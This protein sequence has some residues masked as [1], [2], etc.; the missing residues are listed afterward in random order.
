MNTGKIFSI[1]KSDSKIS[2]L[3]CGVFP[4]DCLPED[5]PRPAAFVINT[6]PQTEP[7]AHWVSIYIDGDGCGDYFDSYGGKP[8][9]TF[10]TFLD[11]NCIT[12]QYSNKR[13]QTALTSVCGQYCIYFLHFRCR[14]FSLQSILSRFGDDFVKN[15]T[16]VTNFVNRKYDINTELVDVNFI[17]DQIAKEFV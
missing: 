5:S 1:C 15:D 13:V 4:S 8:M 14:D 10:K 17:V 11:R 7:G 16:D 3:F 6:D 9:K 2:P 12:W